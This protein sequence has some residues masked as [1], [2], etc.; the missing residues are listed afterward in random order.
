MV[1]LNPAQQRRHRPKFKHCLTQ[2]VPVPTGLAFP[3]ENWIQ[4][5][6]IM[7]DF[8]KNLLTSEHWMHCMVNWFF[9]LYWDLKGGVYW[10]RYNVKLVQFKIIK[11]TNIFG[12]F[13]FLQLKSISCQVNESV[14][15]SGFCLNM[16]M[17]TVAIFSG[18]IYMPG[19]KRNLRILC[20]L[21]EMD[22]QT[23]P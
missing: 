14:C 21:K 6:Y 23:F 10:H 20:A 5:S 17:N 19:R 16:K 18:Y 15:F 9:F 4:K 13:L 3:P 8:E 12:I 2:I 7:L 22:S 11:V 1:A